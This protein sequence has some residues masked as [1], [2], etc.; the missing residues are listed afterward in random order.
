MADDD[1]AA[2][3]TLLHDGD[4]RWRTL[5]AEGEEWLDEVRSK[6][7]F[8]RMARPGRGGVMSFR[9]TPEPADRDPRWKLWL[10]PPRFRADVGYPHQT[11]MLMIG[12]GRRIAT[13]HP[14]VAHLRVSEQRDDKPQVGGPPGELL[15]PFRL[16]AALHLAVEGRAASVGREVFVVR[17]RVRRPEERGPMTFM[18]ADE[19]RFGLD[20]ERGALLWLEQLLDKR[21]YR[22]VAMTT[23]AFDEQLDPALFEFPDLPEMPEGALPVPG[24]PRRLPAPHHRQGPPDGVLGEPVAG[25]TVVARTGEFAIA[26]DRVVAYPTGFE[27]GVTV[28]TQDEQVLGSFDDIRRRTWSGSAAFPGESLRF[29]VVFADGRT[30]T[31]DNFPPRPTSTGDVRLVPLGGGGS[32]I[33]HDQRFWVEPLPPPGPLGVVVEWER[34]GLAETRAELDAGAI[35]DAAAKAETLW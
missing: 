1:L 8:L 4:G 31:V 11:R 33:R 14:G 9:G 7:A 17:G 2:V 23:V 32:Q 18:G 21:P 20:A 24:E 3:L 35:L 19:V 28:R 29:G 16:P 25:R 13:S 5:R 34:R 10:A 27:L 12:D 30:S 26:V 15:R 6:E 22:R